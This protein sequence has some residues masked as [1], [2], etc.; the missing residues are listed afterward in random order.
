MHG[1]NE[2]PYPWNTVRVCPGCGSK[3]ITIRAD[4][5]V[6]CKRCGFHLYLNVAAAVAGLIEDD[7]GRVLLTVRASDPMQGMLDL[8]GGF[9]DPDETAED[10]L[11]REIREELNLDAQRCSFRYLGSFPNAY[12]Y[13]GVTYRTLD[14]AFTCTVKSFAPQK[15]SEEIREVRLLKPSEIPLDQ[16]GF[17]S[18]RAILQA[19]LK[20]RKGA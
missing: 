10:A 7:I 11:A 5:S 8:P 6:Q 1:T 14:Q 15:L 18:I 4:R 3:N 12:P 17:D 9:V 20:S 19:Y 2:H 16:V 13:D